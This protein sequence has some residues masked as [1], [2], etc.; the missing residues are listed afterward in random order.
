V[1][2]GTTDGYKRRGTDIWC[3]HSSGGHRRL[4]SRL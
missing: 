2:S 4:G 1:I 3:Y